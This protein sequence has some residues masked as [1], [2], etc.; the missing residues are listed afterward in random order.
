LNVRPGLYA[1]SSTYIH[2]SRYFFLALAVM[3]LLGTITGVFAQSSQVQL[4]ISSA[5]CSASSAGRA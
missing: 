5:G 3:G 4:T 1:F 2:I